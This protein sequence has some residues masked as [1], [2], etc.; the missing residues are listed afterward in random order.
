MA[1][2][3][4]IFRLALRLGVVALGVAVLGLPVYDLFRY[5]LLLLLFVI[6]FTG[7]VTSD[8]KRWMLALGVTALAI[9]ANSLWPAPRIEEGYNFYFDTPRVIADLQLPGDVG[10]VMQSQFD[11][12][13]PGRERCQNETFPERARFGF[14]ADAI[15]KQPKFSRQVM[16]IDFSDPVHLRL[17]DINKLV[18]SALTDRC[19][20]TRFYRDKHSLNLFDRFH[21]LYPLYLVYEFPAAFT[22]SDLCWRGTV[23]W[24]RGDGRFDTLDHG[25]MECRRLTGDDAGR[26]IY[27]VSI[28]RDRSLAMHLKANTTIEMRRLTEHAITIAGL[29]ALLVLLVK[30]QVRRTYLPALFLALALLV[31]MAVDITFI[32]GQ[33][34][35]DDGDDG[36]AYEGFAREMV[37]KAR[38]GDVSGVLMGHEPVYYFTPGF[39]YFRMLERFVFG[40]TYLGY[41]SAMLAMPFVILALFRRFMSAR[42]A[43]G[44]ALVFTGIPV[45]ALFGSSLL[46][47]IVWAARGFAD[48]IAY[49]FLF[50][51]IYLIVPKT[52]EIDDPSPLRGFAGALSLATAT[53][54]RPNLV[55]A[56]VVMIFGA[57]LMAMA[58]HKMRRAIAICAS[59]SFLIVSPLHNLYYGHKAVIFSDNV[60]QPQTL[61]MSPLDYL[62][63]VIEIATLNLTGPHV[64]GAI[65]QLSGW[66]AGPSE[67][68]I[69]IP[70]HAAA[71][72]TLIRVG[73]F[74]RT[75]DPWLRIVALAALLQHGIGVS[76]ANSARYSF[77][78]WLLTALVSAVWLEAEGLGLARRFWPR[79]GQIGSNT[80]FKRIGNGLD[81]LQSFSR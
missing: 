67:L 27:A 34:P 26:S 24:P 61:L 18:Y 16:G 1:L 81:R 19:G 58:R 59:F 54:C 47:Y 39:R 6:V 64:I 22:G 7:S 78:A 38:A 50:S 33:R 60:N 4:P 20:V 63:A 40:D 55:L 13:Y 53:F 52:A 75:F 14:S 32:G 2:S 15:F 71:I 10:G 79:L 29:I 17:G 43:L 25:S 56:S 62:K 57:T 80:I 69:M 49:L 23:L 74:G 76:Y 36:F 73:L 70:V 37:V 65:R 21:L 5:A 48:P 35:V 30:F 9:T 72:A 77:G 45:G 31:T 51:G 41:L 44:L 66:L 68:L 28:K 11:A 42:W 46:H 8:R 3:S 12:E